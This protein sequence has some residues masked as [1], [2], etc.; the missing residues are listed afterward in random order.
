MKK[1]EKT[2]KTNRE[3]IE[4]VERYGAH[5]YH[6]LP[7]VLTEG[8]GCWCKDVEGKRYL[9]MLSSY[10]A[11]NQG[12]RHPRVLKTMREQSGRITLTSRAFH[13]DLM[14]PFLKKLCDLCGMEKALPMNTGAEGVETAI[15]MARRWGYWKKHIPEGKAEIVVAENNFHGRTTGVVSFST[16]EHYRRGFGPF[17]PGFV[18]VPFGDAAAVER[19]VNPNTCAVLLEPIQGE[20]GIIIPPDGYLT[21]VREICTARNALFILDEIQT[22]LGRTGKLFAWQHEPKAKP[23]AIVLGKALGG[24]VMPVSAVVSS[25]EILGVF[26]PGSHGSTFGGN[27]LA[28]AVASTALDV[29]VEEKLADNAAEIGK[30]FVQGLKDLKSPLVREVR[31][32]GLLI[33]VEL[34]KEAGG[35]HRY[36]ELLLAEGLLCKETREDVIRFAPPL[37]VKWK[38]VEWALK[39]VGKVLQAP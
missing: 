34:T 32:R 10:S 12:H 19:A 35:A 11:L 17:L 22:G 14:G 26:D 23:D 9:D 25:E 31:G 27:P 1:A 2:P 16:E 21:K 7:V 5:N 3:H 30:R 28:C 8:R 39:R 36:C 13:N 18:I 15:K 4:M 20:G 24:G 29:I 37:V 6:P 38:D 33:G